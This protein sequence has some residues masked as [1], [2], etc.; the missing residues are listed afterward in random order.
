MKGRYRTAMW[1]GRLWLLAVL[2]AGGSASCGDGGPP[3]TQPEVPNRAPSLVG[4]VAVQTVLEGSTV[5]VNVSSYF[6]DPDGDPL[7]YGASSSN[8]SVATASVSG[9]TVNI[10]GVAAGAAVITVTATDP[11]GSQAQQQVGVTVER[12]NQAPVAV[13]TIPARTMTVGET[14]AIDLTPFFSDPDGDV[15]SYAAATSEAA[16]AD[17]SVSSDTLTITAG[18]EGTATVTVAARDP[19]GLS[20]SQEPRGGGAQPGAGGGRD[21]PRPDNGHGR[22]GHH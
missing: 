15:L 16:V 14:A 22:D 11:S 6:S 18:G 1:R 5:T 3:P 19:E 12:A 4:T 7:T 17:V 10:T 20:A 9:A 8:P 13:G 2:T 21:H